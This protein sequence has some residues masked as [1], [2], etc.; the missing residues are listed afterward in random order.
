MRCIQKWFMIK[1]RTM[2]RR[3]RIDAP[4]ALQHVFCRGIER[5]KIYRD[6]ADRE[7]FLARLETILSESQTPCYAWALMPNHFH[8]LL[9]TGNSPIAR[10]MS[11]L[12]SGY[13]G[14]FNRRHGRAGH[15]FQNRYKSILCQD[16]PYLLE[17]VR[18]IHLNPLRRR[19]ATSI[20]QL[21]RYRYSGHSA[22]MGH[23]T[24]DW[25][26][27]DAVLRLLGKSVSKARRHY[28]RF[29]E[30]KTG[31]ALPSALSGD[32]FSLRAQS[33][34]RDQRSGSRADP[35]FRQAA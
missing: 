7:D 22:L 8:L 19:Q 34:G 31:S 16:D 25:Q 17:L 28:R 27:V 33:G 6:D 12:L 9:R 1:R 35:G 29:A 11:R 13:A 5:R 3:S 20:S 4:G 15:L 26:A 18:Y 14:R 32:R 2:P 30:R 10:V 23:R 24:N 21:D